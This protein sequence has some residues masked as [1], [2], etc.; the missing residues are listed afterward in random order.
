MSLEEQFCT[1]VLKSTTPSKNQRFWLA[2]VPIEWDQDFDSNF[3][4]KYSLLGYMPH[5]PED[6]SPYYTRSHKEI[7]EEYKHIVFSVLPIPSDE[8][9]KRLAETNKKICAA[10]AKHEKDLAKM[11]E[12]MNAAREKPGFNEE[13]W[14]QQRKLPKLEELQKLYELKNELVE[15][16]DLPHSEA[17]QAVERNVKNPGFEE[18]NLGGRSEV[19][20]SYDITEDASE[21]ALNVRLGKANSQKS[22][23]LS[24]SSLT[25]EDAATSGGF[26]AGLKE[27]FT[28]IFGAGENAE[29]KNNE[30]IISIKVPS[31]LSAGS[32]N[33]VEDSNMTDGFMHGVKNLFGFA[34]KAGYKNIDEEIKSIEVKF[35]AFI[36]VRVTPGAWYKSDYLTQVA[37][38]DRWKWNTSAREIFKDF[39]SIVT[40]FV[41]VYGPS[42][43][44]KMSEHAKKKT[45]LALKGGLELSIPPIVTG[46]LPGVST[47]VEASRNSQNSD[48]KAS[49]KGNSVTIE[50]GSKAAAPQILG[51]C[52]E[53]P[54]EV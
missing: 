38:E 18:V 3:M 19:Y 22:F 50:L 53:K 51:F 7:Y 8:H 47:D 45:E 34:A 1:K 2:N 49:F 28:K 29:C 35:E 15:K 42:L 4:K 14:K 36:F 12:A 33:N 44:I 32:A 24:T 21:W 43:T 40:G 52:T 17:I 6:G 39:H 20:P 27:F 13:E 16:W 30:E 10:E 25:L 31:E 37:R 54:V 9:A 26:E 48:L 41:A 11:N 5:A 23:K 46:R